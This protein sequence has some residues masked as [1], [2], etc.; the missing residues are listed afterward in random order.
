MGSISRRSRSSSIGIGGIIFW[1]IMIS[2]WFG[3]CDDDKA[4]KKAEVTDDKSIRDTLKD[5]VKDITPEVKSIINKAKVTF[6]EYKDGKDEEVIV[7]KKQVKVKEKYEKDDIY[8]VDE[9]KW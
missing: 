9:D 4:E 2:M 8:A 3:W 1:G 6:Q 7:K 5:T